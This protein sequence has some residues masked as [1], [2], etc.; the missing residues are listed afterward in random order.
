MV[1]GTGYAAA[2]DVVAHEL[3]HGYVERT[4]GLFYFHQSGAINESVSDVIGEI[5]DHRNPASTA[6]DA[7]W[8]SARTSRAAADCA[9]S[10]TL[11]STVSRTG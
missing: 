4:S 6:S 1:F 10:R 3:T 5:V 9:A 8:T 2:D 7:D 11:R